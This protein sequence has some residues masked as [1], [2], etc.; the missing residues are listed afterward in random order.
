M[1]DKSTSL[2]AA[3]RIS[4]PS[5]HDA[6]EPKSPHAAAGLWKPS[7]ISDGDTA[8]ALFEHSEQHCEPIDP[9]AEARLLRKIDLVILPCLV[10]CYAFYY[11]SPPRSKR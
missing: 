8:Q 11:A 4:S 2:Q 7:K 1:A 9:A 10:V 6:A 3:E 5:I